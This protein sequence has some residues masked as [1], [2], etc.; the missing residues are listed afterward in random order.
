MSYK[1]FFRADDY[2]QNS[3]N[4]VGFFTTKAEAESELIHKERQPGPCEGDFSQITE[5]VVPKERVKGV[6]PE[7]TQLMLSQEIWGDA[8]IIE[9]YYYK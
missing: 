4:I 5:F 8:T 9:T 1:K 7:E 2:F 6:D 3:G